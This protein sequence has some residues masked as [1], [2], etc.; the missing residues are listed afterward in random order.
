[1]K[2]KYKKIITKSFRDDAIKSAILIDDNYITYETLSDKAEL[3]LS[4]LKIEDGT[5]L[6][7]QL[8][9]VKQASFSMKE[10]SL[11]KDIKN[12]F[13]DLSIVCDV[14]NATKSLDA[15]KIRKSDLVV[16]DYMMNGSAE[17]SL[18]LISK[19]S[20]NPH[21]NVVVVYTNEDLD[22]TWLEIAAMLRGFSL[23]DGGNIGNT[24]NW[25]REW[26][27]FIRNYSPDNWNVGTK[28]LSE[29]VLS[30]KISE[31]QKGLPISR[32]TPRPNRELICAYVETKLKQVCIA[33]DYLAMHGSDVYGQ[34]DNEAPWIQ[35][36]NVFITLVSKN[37]DD[38]AD[39]LHSIYELLPYTKSKCIDKKTIHKAFI[40]PKIYSRPFKVWHQISVS[41]RLWNPSTY[42]IIASELQNRIENGNLSVGS[43]QS[44]NSKQEAALLWNL[45]NRKETDYR[46]G[47]SQ[48]LGL[49]LEDISDDLHNE[50]ESNILDFIVAAAKSS[51]QV[52][53]MLEYVAPIKG[54]E[55]DYK[56]Y[57]KQLF[58][59]VTNNA[60][61]T[62][63]RFNE[64]CAQEIIHALNV[65]LST[66]NRIPSYITTGVIL[67]DRGINPKL[68]TT[69]LVPQLDANEMTQAISES[70]VEESDPSDMIVLS[71]EDIEAQM[72][73]RSIQEISSVD[74][75]SNNELQQELNA[76]S[77]N[78]VAPKRSWYLCVTPSCNTVPGQ[79]TDE[80]TAKIQPLRQQTL[81]R[82]EKV[83]Y[84][85]ELKVASQSKS[86]FIEHEGELLAFRLV[87]AITALP[88]IEKV[89]VLDHDNED[90]TEASGKQVC[91]LENQNGRPVY[92]ERTLYPIAR[93]KAAYAARYQN[94]QSH[95]EGR[96]GVDFVP[97]N[98]S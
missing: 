22:T 97:L 52:T 24:D 37:V 15:D 80:V 55:A 90:M 60:D 87:D 8:E 91:F 72:E 98:L 66:T 58:A 63:V 3:L 78:E 34:F 44:K 31:V 9:K 61:R 4:T 10:S 14:E 74:S 49:M 93:L 20:N 47:A 89:I 38:A 5:E 42:R 33:R 51:N 35:A 54:N 82:L 76:I 36:G 19:L 43:P 41:L 29:Y 92:N 26:D 81:L 77:Q 53:P 64:Q 27:D 56:A 57:L 45:I 71:P 65:E 68:D 32:G 85:S 2:N 83:K 88:N 62:K 73:E 79:E 13:N 7:A 67:V 50:S 30:G 16:L 39:R 70:A 17:D 11:A 59:L 69:R 40:L 1:M 95:Y 25:E 6:Q 23:E 28:E 18:K 75:D 21:M 46:R 94:L 12:Y 96:I 48:I 84:Q 86:I